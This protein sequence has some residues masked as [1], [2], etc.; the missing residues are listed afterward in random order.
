M[1]RVALGHV[2]TLIAAPGG[3]GGDAEGAEG[4]DE[5][6]AGH[7]GPGLYENIRSLISRIAPLPLAIAALGCGLAGCGGGRAEAVRNHTIGLRLDEYRIIPQRISAPAGPLRIIVRN[8][9]V[10][11]HNLAVLTIP[12]DPEAQPKVLGRTPTVHPGERADEWVVGGHRRQTL[13][14]RPGRYRLACTLANHDD[15]GQF[16]TLIVR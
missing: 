8:R 4:E 7:C 1:R 2:D 3:H 16:G 9:G 6:A 10:L 12:S 14:L 5:T 13:D 11:T 15:L